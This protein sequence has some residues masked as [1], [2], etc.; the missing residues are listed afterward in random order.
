MSAHRSHHA[1]LTAPT[2]GQVPARTVESSVLC[3]AY[4]DYEF[5]NHKMIVNTIRHYDLHNEVV[6]ADTAS[7]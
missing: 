1:Y 7:V 4:P 3:I 2:E 5:W 6:F